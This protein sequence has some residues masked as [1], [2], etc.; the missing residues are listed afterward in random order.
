MLVPASVS[1]DAANAPAQVPHA[2]GVPG[3]ADD[4]ADDERRADGAALSL[5]WSMPTDSAVSIDAIEARNV[6]PSD[7]SSS[8]LTPCTDDGM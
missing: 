2:L 6:A 8:S 4:H 3:A 5:C 7:V 1:T